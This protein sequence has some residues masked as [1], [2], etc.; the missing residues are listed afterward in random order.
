MRYRLH[1]YQKYTVVYIESHSIATV[2]L[3][4]GLGKTSI[5]LTALSHLLFDSFEVHKIL[6]VVRVTKNTWGTE[7]EK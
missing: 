7:I 3:D 2:L 6:I 1:D 4:M 5:M